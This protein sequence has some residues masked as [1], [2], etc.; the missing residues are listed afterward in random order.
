LIDYFLTFTFAPDMD[1]IMAYEHSPLLLSALEHNMLIPYVLATVLFYYAAGR[2]ILKQLEGSELY[3]T[4]VLII[5]TLSL[6][7]IMGGF[8]WYVLNESY[9]NFVLFMSRLSVIVSIAA[10]GYA[11]IGRI[12]RTGQ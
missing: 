3:L 4:G 10:L 12:P 2:F 9:S 11:L 5:C 6:T 8:S 7:H 1:A